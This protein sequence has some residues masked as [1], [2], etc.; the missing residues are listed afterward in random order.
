MFT[1]R[2]IFQVQRDS[3]KP[4]KKKNEQLVMFIN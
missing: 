4:L 2:Y 3:K 1:N